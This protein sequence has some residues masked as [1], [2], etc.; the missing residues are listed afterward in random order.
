M[1][2]QDAV[3]DMF[4]ASI[5][6]HELLHVRV[7]KGMSDTHGNHVL[8]P[9]IEITRTPMEK[10]NTE[11]SGD[12]PTDS[13]HTFSQAATD[14]PKL[15]W[16]LGQSQNGFRQSTTLRGPRFETTMVLKNGK[17]EKYPSGFYGVDAS[18]LVISRSFHDDGHKFNQDAIRTESHDH[19]ESPMLPE[20]HDSPHV[21]KEKLIQMFEEI[22]QSADG[23]NSTPHH[24]TTLHAT[25]DMT[26][27][28]R[29][30]LKF[31]ETPGLAIT[32]KLG[33]ARKQTD[34]LREPSVFV[35]TKPEDK[36][37]VDSD[38]VCQ[39]VKQLMGPKTAIV[40]MRL[41]PKEAMAFMYG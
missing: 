29:E 10:D 16:H 25:E 37:L 32:R 17:V 8:E 15:Q 39:R 19:K 5:R 4:T 31:R 34:L 20:S 2:V 9:V 22:T 38:T 12:N 14:F 26:N 23:A 24:T 11:L 35:K 18:E 33:E 7:L 30:Y 21:S 36:P 6:N 27:N 3:D 13:S 40:E 28:D 1:R 41:R